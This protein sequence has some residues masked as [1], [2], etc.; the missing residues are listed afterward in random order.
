MNRIGSTDA[1]RQ[2]ASI[3]PNLV[4]WGAVFSGTV[5]ALGFFALVSTLWLGIAYQDADASGWISGN[6]AWFIAGTAIVSLFLAGL[7]AGALSGVRGTAAGAVNGMTA[8]GL[9]FVASLL[10]VVPSLAAITNSLGAGLAAGTN[11][12]GS[13]LGQTGGG[14]TAA[15]G[16]WATF[17]S[18]LIGAVAA[19]VGGM[20]GGKVKRQVPVAGVD[21]RAGDESYPADPVAS[22]H[23]EDDPVV[24]RP[25]GRTERP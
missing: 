23:V 2:G 10:T 5:I 15:S 14:L 6:L 24:I 17:W 7:L 18:L 1:A 12:I 8:W 9:L 4:R 19:A 20:L 22:V 21:T 3:A 25:A 16:V 11:E 13:A